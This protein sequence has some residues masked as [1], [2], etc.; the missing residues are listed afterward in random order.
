MFETMKDTQFAK[1]VVFINASVPATMIA[2]DAFGGASA[3]PVG[4]A[5]QRTGKF[6]LIL[7]L[8][9]LCVT[10]LRKL[11]GKN[12]F[13]HFRKMLGLF[14]F[15]YAS[16]HLLIYFVFDRQLNVSSLI[17]ETL[18]RKFILFGMAALLMM[19]PLALTSTNASIKRLGAARWKTLHKLAYLSA[20]AG[21]AHYWISVKKDI[22]QPLLF[23][24]ALTILFAYRLYY[25]RP[26]PKRPVAAA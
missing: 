9:S 7:L 4:Y 17:E 6:A 26:Q 2:W 3:D 21:V 8:L 19:V 24:I 15:F 20:I 11:T 23:A 16:L 25:S 14:A 13:S 18:K 1:L 5:L 12:Y 10:P 22:R